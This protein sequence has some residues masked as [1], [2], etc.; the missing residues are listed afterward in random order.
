MWLPNPD[1]P[2]DVPE[3]VHRLRLGR[4]ILYGL[5][6]GAYTI[7]EQATPLDEIVSDACKEILILRQ[8][9][10][11]ELTM[12]DSDIDAL[13]AKELSGLPQGG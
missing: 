13:V 4:A 10:R 2:D 5:L 9:I 8:L 11:G 3:I 6:T 7:D 12:A 1:D